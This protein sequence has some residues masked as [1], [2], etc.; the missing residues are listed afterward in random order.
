MEN[1]VLPVKD[2]LFGCVNRGWLKTFGWKLPQ[3]ITRRVFL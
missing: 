3:I 1:V 2:F